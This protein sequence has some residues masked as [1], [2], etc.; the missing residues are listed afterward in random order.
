MM[1]TLFLIVAIALSIA[2]WLRP[3]DITFGSIGPPTTGSAIEA[4][5]TSLTI[6]LALPISVK[7]PNF[8]AAAFKTISATAYYPINNVAIGGG[9]K[10]DIT[11]PSNSETTFNFPFSIDYTQAKDPDRTILNDIANRCGFTGNSRQ[12]INVKYVITL[13]MKILAFT[14]S[15]S[16]SGS[17]GFDCPLTQAQLEPFLGSL[18]GG[19]S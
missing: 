17:T 7:N 19:G 16:F 12:K 5:T 9:S 2:M 14:I 4:S 18:T 1:S 3:P 11:F 13:K 10:D 6:N 15:P 8:F